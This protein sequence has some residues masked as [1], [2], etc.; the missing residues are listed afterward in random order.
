MTNEQ[1]TILI[2][3]QFKNISIPRNDQKITSVSSSVDFDEYYLDRIDVVLRCINLLIAGINT[4]L[5]KSGSI[6]SNIDI[7]GYP[8]VNISRT[9]DDRVKI[10]V[11]FIFG[12][13]NE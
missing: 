13:D 1:I 11:T 6:D 4:K 10:S 12:S 9:I 7:S 3:K 5:L 2:L 8:N